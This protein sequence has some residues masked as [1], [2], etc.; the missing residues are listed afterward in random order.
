MPIYEWKCPTCEARVDVIRK[1][2]EYT[3][4]PTNEEHT[5]DCHGSEPHT[6]ERAIRAPK[7][8]RGRG[9]EGKGHWGNH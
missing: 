5:K 3:D 8:V 2:E 9:W 1:F 4:E 7:V 6:W